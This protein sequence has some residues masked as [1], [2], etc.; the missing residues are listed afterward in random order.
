[1]EVA[2]STQ[3]SIVQ[4]RSSWSHQ[5]GRD[6]TSTKWVR[7]KRPVPVFCTVQA[8]SIAAA[9]SRRESLVA[10]GCAIHTPPEQGKIA[11]PKQ[12]KEGNQQVKRPKDA[13]VDKGGDASFQGQQ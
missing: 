12:K 3:L 11:G 7:I 13:S 8:F 1:M 4:C 10:L 2:N 9:S 6:M 5:P